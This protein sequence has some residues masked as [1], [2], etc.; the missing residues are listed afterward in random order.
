MSKSAL[1]AAFRL[2][3]HVLLLAAVLV[4]LLF[5][6]HA[7]LRRKY[8]DYRFFDIPLAIGLGLLL[9]SHFVVSLF[10]VPSR[11]MQPALEVGDGIAVNRLSYHFRKPQVGEI[12]VFDLPKERPG[13][14][15]TLVKRMA[16]DEG[17][18][19]R[20]EGGQVYRN[21]QLDSSVKVSTEASI[22]EHKIAPGCIFVLGDNRTMSMDS[23]VY[24]DI[25]KAWL[26]G[27]VIYRYWPPSRIGGVR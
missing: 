24:G 7:G 6:C 9:T 12:V 18:I 2:G 1:L 20:I 23:R 5:F 4:R 16:A 22:K 11:S 14:G 21:D 27:P 19:I 26:Y 25:P 13:G 3:G 8:K 17:D 10:Y 15:Q